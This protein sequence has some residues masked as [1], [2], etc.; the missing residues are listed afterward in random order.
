M[1]LLPALHHLVVKAGNVLRGLFT[2]VHVIVRI[3]DVRYVCL[4][5]RLKQGGLTNRVQIFSCSTVGRTDPQM[6][7]SHFGGNWIR[8]KGGKRMNIGIDACNLATYVNF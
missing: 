8:G 5:V 7:A 6:T 4:L 1:L 3:Y 2:Y